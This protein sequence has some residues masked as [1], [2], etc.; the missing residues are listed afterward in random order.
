MV[1]K[2]VTLL[3][4]CS[5]Q[6]DDPKR[7][8]RPM[9]TIRLYQH[10]RLLHLRYHHIIELA[11]LVLTVIFN[12]SEEMSAIRTSIMHANRMQLVSFI[13]LPKFLIYS[14]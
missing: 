9:A 14:F 6:I 1:V 8:H 12:E 10:F 2:L 3:N 5:A 7:S 4:L 13:F 11:P